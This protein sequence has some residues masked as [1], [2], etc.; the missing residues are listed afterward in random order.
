MRFLVRAW[1]RHRRENRFLL[2]AFVFL[3]TL[4]TGAFYLLQRAQSVSP[5][6]LT[7][8][9]LLFIL[10][11]LDISLILILSFVIVRNVWSSGGVVSSAAAFARNWSSLMS[12]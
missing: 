4:T 3:M 5:D 9:L 1:N 12:P 7:N 8:R 10:W 2:G 6:E 11:Y